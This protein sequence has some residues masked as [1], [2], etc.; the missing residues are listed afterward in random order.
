[1]CIRDRSSDIKELIALAEEKAYQ[2]GEGGSVEQVD[3]MTVYAKILADKIRQGTGKDKPLQGMKIIVDAGNGA[4]GFYV[5]KVLKPLGA[6]T[7]LLYTSFSCSLS[8]GLV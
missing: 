8:L 1:M 5:E 2:K 7:C 4:G 6:D 3:F